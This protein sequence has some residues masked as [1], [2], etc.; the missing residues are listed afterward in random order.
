MTN[1]I[2]PNMRKIEYRDEGELQQNLLPRFPMYS[3]T[4]YG[5]VFSRRH[6][7]GITKRW[8]KITP[9]LEKNGYLRIA[10]TSASG[11]KEKMSIHRLVLL[12]FVGE[13]ELDCRHLDGNSRNNHILNLKYG[14]A[15]ENAYDRILHGT[16]VSSFD[17][18]QIKNIFLL[19]S[20]GKTM[21]ELSKLFNVNGCTILSIL[22]R[23]TYKHVKIDPKILELIKE[24]NPEICGKLNEES[25]LKIFEMRAA[26]MSHSEISKEF[27]V[28]SAAICG[29]LNRRYWSHVEIPESLLL[30]VKNMP[31]LGVPKKLK[32]SDK[33]EIIKLSKENVSLGEIAIRFNVCKMSIWRI[34]SN[35]RHKEEKLHLTSP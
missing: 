5:D 18:N 2:T 35:N 19:S 8:K 25:V 14:T 24:K 13:S 21:T 17:E 29:T 22:Y 33:V 31:K 1:G 4:E 15:K 6:R 32:P 30:A 20:Q 23:K 7:N 28:K 10:L 27:G 12:A 9:Y 3:V 11:Q 16:N 26:G 34:V